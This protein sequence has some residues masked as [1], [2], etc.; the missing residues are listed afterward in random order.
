MFQSK[1]VKIIRIYLVTNILYL[2]DTATRL[3]K[4]FS[5]NQMKR[6]MDKCH[7]LMSKDKSIR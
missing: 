5:A 2:Q 3:F 6:N 7:L 4:W 1:A